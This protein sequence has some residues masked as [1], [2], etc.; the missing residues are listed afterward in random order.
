MLVINE[1]EQIVL[2]NPAAT[3][4]FK[5]DL[6]K[7]IDKKCGEFFGC[8][9]RSINE[10]GCG[11]SRHC[12]TCEVANAIKMCLNNHKTTQNKETSVIL[13]A[14]DGKPLLWIQF[15]TETLIFNRKK[16]MILSVTDITTRKEAEDQIHKTE[17]RFKSLIEHAPDGVVLIGVEG[18]FKYVSNSAL[19]IFGYN[20]NEIP[21]ASPNELTHPDDLPIV[22]SVLEKLVHN[23]SF[24][25]TIEYRFKKKDGSW[26]WVQSTFSNMLNDPHVEAIV[27][28]FRDIT[29][30]IEAEEALKESETKYREL[31]DA[32]KDGI[33]IFYIEPDD[34][35]GQFV[36]VNKA[37]AEMLG[38]TKEEFLNFSPM[39][40]EASA[41]IFI[42]EKREKEIR[43]KGF[44]S[45]ET[46]IRHKD[47][48]LIEIELHVILIRYNNRLALMNI[49]RDISE[50]KRAE[51]ALLEKE[52]QL[53]T[54]INTTSDIICF[55]D[56]KGRW[57]RAN[58]AILNLY[59]LDHSNYYGKD[60]AE[61]AATTLKIFRDAFKNCVNSDEA[62]WNNKNMSILDEIIPLATGE[63]KTYEVAK[64][65]LF[66]PDGSRKGMVIFGRDIT[67]RKEDEKALKRSEQ[68]YRL[69]AD[70]VS[71]VIWTMDRDFKYTFISPSIMQLRGLSQAEAMIEPYDKSMTPE[72]LEIVNKI[73]AQS[74]YSETKGKVVEPGIIEIQQ[75]H[76]N[77]SIIWV[78]IAIHSIYN[79]EGRR[80]GTIGVSRDITKRKQAEDDLKES[81]QQLLDI[82]D[83][84]P[85]ATF[86]IDNDKK[87]IAWNK[88]M[89]EMSGV[90][91]EQMIGKGDHEYAIPFYGKRQKQLLDLIDSPDTE[92]L[93]R[94]NNVSRNGD[95]IYAEIYA[96][97]LHNDKGA[98]ISNVGAP[99]YNSSGKRIGSIESIRDITDR[100]KAEIDLKA[101]E[102]RYR[103]M[104]DLLPDAVF[105][106]DGENVFFANEATFKLI[107]IKSLTD[108][109]GK[110]LMDFVH[111]EF[112]AK[113]HKRVKHVFSSG[114]PVKFMEFK[115]LNIDGEPIEVESVGI[116]ITYMGKPAIQ[117]IA[118]DITERKQ[119]EE[120]LLTLSRSV[121]Q[122]TISIV[123]TDPSGTIKYVNPRFTQ[124]TG[125]S[126]DE[127]IGTNPSILKSG[128]TSDATYKELW[129]TILSGREWKGEFHNKKKNG[130]LFWEDANISPIVNH[131]GQITHFVGIKEDITNR[132]LAEEEI[133][134]LNSELELRVNQRTMQLELANKELEAFSYSVSHDLRAPLRGIDG[135]S[136]ALMEDNG[137]Q[138]DDKGHI[139]LNRVRTEAQRMGHLI[140]DLLKLSRV[141]RFEMNRL[142]IDLTSLAETIADRL[143]ETHPDREIEFIIKPGLHVSGDP[144][145]IEIVLTNLFDNACKFT[146]KL[147]SAAKIEFGTTMDKGQPAFFVRDN[148]VGFDMENAKKLFGAFQRMHKQTEFQGTGIGLAT[149]Q[150]IIHRHGGKIWAT[151]KLN[152]GAV[153][154]FTINVL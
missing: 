9:N 154:Y 111:P 78:E 20:E 39:Q 92:I 72:S 24:V 54:L 152:E 124:V 98:Y 130:E 48:S 25:P 32:N 147:L 145:M 41:D 55:K 6:N 63:L 101:S 60:D 22:L 40:L 107:G 16:H 17:K 136:L 11:H 61:L 56:G 139:Y 123:I 129:Q 121:E 85:D 80:A 143:R 79:N 33:S 103:S 30:R 21:I 148:G 26:R 89:V 71:D 115:F 104:V 94:Y 49:V 73:M 99:L 134:K 66:F 27:I 51:A 131:K 59:G 37:A 31:F 62:T 4:L 77:G 70:N 132:K 14:A 138:L 119:T 64:T 137:D 96:P 2:V 90:A 151:S 76:K 114:K 36:E 88:A 82:I 45:T 65:P 142:E 10:K 83:F 3:K 128:E 84:L 102:E 44:A 127:T 15:S 108:A 106:H 86:V 116:P 81:R 153:F 125:Y 42:L 69:L 38:Y 144:A 120:K 50:R 95:S 7:L 5:K 112:K 28:N 47:G 18:T 141:N 23:P 110:S 67:R 12:Q 52:E 100:R 113:A 8:E 146:G 149:V 117:S 150:R 91:K 29:T 135:W 53:S 105:I 34:K 87:V 74:L 43:E 46:K 75:Y 133:R 126:M 1:E 122:S 109:P 13:E 93:E 97:H 58:D 68:M 57:L 35:P 140:D 118:R 19:K